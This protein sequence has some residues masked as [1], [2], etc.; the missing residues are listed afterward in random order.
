M[1]YNEQ[2]LRQ[3]V[4]DYIQYKLVYFMRFEEMKNIIRDN[5]GI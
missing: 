1:T 2:R 4:L 3:L 5:T